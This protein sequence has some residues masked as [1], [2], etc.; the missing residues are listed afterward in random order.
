MLNEPNAAKKVFLAALER[1][2]PAERAAYL[3]EACQADPEL[4]QRVEALLQ[5]HD[6]AA[7][8]LEKPLLP[9]AP[10][11]TEQA[12]VAPSVPSDSVTADNAATAPNV[13][14][15]LGTRIRYLGDYELVEEIA[16]GGMGVVYKARQLSLNRVVALKMILSGQFASAADVQRFQTEAEA[17]ANLDHPNI[18]PIYEVGEFE[19]QHYFS[20]KLIEGTSLAQAVVS[21]QWPVAGKD[22][23]EKSAR[24]LADAARAVHHAHQRGILHRDLK[25]GN[26][27]LDDKG[28]PHVTDFGVAKRVEG[29]SGQTRTGAIVGTPSYMAPEQARAEKGLTTAADVYSLGAILYEMLTG[30]PPFR[31][32]SPLQ[33]IMLVMEQEP[34]SVRSIQPKIDRDLETICLKC[35]EKDPARRYGS[36]EA[37][38]DD[39]EHWLVGE[40]IVARPM[41]MPERVWRWCRRHP[42]LAATI[43]IIAM[44]VIGVSVIARYVDRRERA[45]TAFMAEQKLDNLKEQQRAEQRERDK[46]RQRLR[47]SLIEQARA[48]R[49]AGQRERSLDALRKAAEIRKDDA[50]RLEASATIQR[51]GLRLAGQIALDNRG[52]LIDPKDLSKI[53][54]NPVAA[55]AVDPTGN[56]VAAFSGRGLDPKDRTLARTLFHELPSGKLVGAR[57]SPFSAAAFRPGTSQIALVE[58]DGQEKPVV[59]LWDVLAGQEVARF[60]GSKD[61]QVIAIS[62]DGSHLLTGRPPAKV[63]PKAKPGQPDVFPN[64]G[65]LIPPGAGTI[66]VWNITTK[67]AG[68]A[69]PRGEVLGFISGHELVFL[70]IDDRLMKWNCLTGEEQQ[71]TPEIFKPVGFSLPARRAAVQSIITFVPDGAP[72]K[73]EKSESVLIWDLDKNRQIGNIQGL[74]IPKLNLPFDRSGEVFFSPNGRYAVCQFPTDQDR[75]L[76]IWDLHLQKFVSRLNCPRGL[77]LRTIWPFEKERT[78][79]SFSP[80]GTLLASVVTTS[81]S[82]LSLCIWDTASGDVLANLPDVKQHWWS[83][84]GQR[85]IVQTDGIACW[86]VS[87]P[88]LSYDLSSSIRSLTLNRDGSRLAANQFV[89]RVVAGERG[90]ELAGWEANMISS[91]P[92]FVGKDE[93]LDVG[94]DLRRQSTSTADASLC[95]ESPGLPV[96]AGRL[97]PPDPLCCLFSQAH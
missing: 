72:D 47:D 82:R 14:P 1:L 48:E 57:K 73:A 85:L 25:P 84:D 74:T 92:Q 70:D 6:A 21:D 3:D 44:A 66:R 96:P 19:G 43:G 17:A 56:L 60:E 77:T 33:T 13:P 41:G 30:R 61:S 35:L 97:W 38:A 7:S 83:S 78:F 39:L 68:K 49:S 29:D 64:V 50:L 16:R 93:A 79:R 26:I 95:R 45:M 94:K 42:E 8:F 36:A 34:A 91:V 18:V 65:Q 24:L 37:L 90:C 89:S 5:A 86:E 22:R 62:T 12:T 40:P 27:L 69:P 11:D 67:R 80:D 55:P 2:S 32:E 23:S 46:D 76:R 75:S 28:Q 81:L 10:P 53:Q 4:R 54:I 88:P 20:M 9:S 31:A 63:F 51:P 52:I 87:R 59:V 15:S 58:S 71:L